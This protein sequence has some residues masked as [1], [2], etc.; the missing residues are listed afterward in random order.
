MS[1]FI[2]VWVETKPERGAMKFSEHWESFD[3]M[4]GALRFYD[5][6]VNDPAVYTATLC[7]PI[8]STDYETAAEVMS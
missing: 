6:L 2:V 1:P 5:Q 8:R 4:T 7:K 3:T